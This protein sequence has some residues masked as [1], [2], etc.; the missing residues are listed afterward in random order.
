MD[1]RSWRE[2]KDTAPA[3][4][5]PEAVSGSEPYVAELEIARKLAEA[6]KSPEVTSHAGEIGRVA[7]TQNFTEKPRSI[8]DEILDFTQGV[9]K[10]RELY[11]SDFE[12]AA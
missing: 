8:E 12:K 1:K 2:H 11:Q 5:S 4:G 10:L 6:G 7:S 3:S 9:T